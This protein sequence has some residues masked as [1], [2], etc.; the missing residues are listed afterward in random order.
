MVWIIVILAAVGSIGRYFTFLT[1][2][3]GINPRGGTDPRKV[4]VGLDRAGKL[5][6]YLYKCA[7]NGGLF[8]IYVF[9]KKMGSFLY[10]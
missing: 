3:G 10:I 5:K 2:Y 8:Y 7:K 1:C 9:D 4:R 6:L